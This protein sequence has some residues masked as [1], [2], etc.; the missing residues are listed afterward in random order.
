[1]SSTSV[2]RPKL[3]KIT[4][5]KYIDVFGAVLILGV[6]LY[7]NFHETIYHN[8]GIQFGIPFSEL[9]DYIAK[10]A[11]PL[12]F[13]SIAGAM[14]SLL[15]T[16]LMVRQQNFGN[17]IWIFTTINSGTIDYLL[18]NTSAILTYPITFG[19]ALLSTKKWY[20]GER[21]KKADTLYFALSAL[22]FVVSYSLVY[23]GFYLFPSATDVVSPFF[24]H[25]IAIIFGISL[26]GNVGIAFK[27]EESFFVWFIYNIMQL[28][29]NALQGNIANVVKYVFYMG[30]AILTYFDWSI[31]G[32]VKKQAFSKNAT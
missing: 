2:P 16:R 29:K 27:Y 20:G 13:L 24:K 10:G 31:N 11:F 14:F 17:V 19:L 3:R 32:D 12:G 28:L 8:G 6:C 26:I 7:R 9:G 21:I 22:A 18:G 5:S 23:L 25:S 1:M 15:S 4:H 30:N